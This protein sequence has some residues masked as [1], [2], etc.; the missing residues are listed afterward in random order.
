MKNL[1]VMEHLEVTGCLGVTERLEVRKVLVKENR[2]GNLTECKT[3]YL[4]YCQLP[5]RKF[6]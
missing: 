6:L 5:H 3:F 1:S 4:R 2:P